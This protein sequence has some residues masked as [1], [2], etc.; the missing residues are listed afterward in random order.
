M[1]TTRPTRSLQQVCHGETETGRRVSLRTGRR[2]KA[3]TRTKERVKE[4]ASSEK[5]PRFLQGLHPPHP[6]EERKGCLFPFGLYSTGKG[7]DTGLPGR[8]KGGGDPPEGKGRWGG[9]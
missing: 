3:P 8:G 9:W 4:S 1:S 6:Q 7:R 2:T 5:L